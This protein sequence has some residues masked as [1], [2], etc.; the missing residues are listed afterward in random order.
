MIKKYV[1]LV[2]FL[3]ALMSTSVLADS[4]VINSINPGLGYIGQA[5]LTVNDDGNIFDTWGYCLEKTAFNY[6]GTWYTG[7]IRELKDE[8]LWQ[9]QLI[10]N[11]YSVGI[12]GDQQAWGLQNAIWGSAVNPP[13]DAVLLKSLYA[14]ADIPNVDYCWGQDFIIAKNSVPEPSTMLMLGFGAVFV[15]MA[16]RKRFN[17]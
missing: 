13:V 2:L 11:V 4:L 1:L 14:W 15:G 16:G 5:N 6:L 9:A 10:Y 7:E 12:P 8:Q 17:K 3:V